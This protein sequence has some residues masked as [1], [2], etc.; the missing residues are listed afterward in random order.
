MKKLLRAGAL[1]LA[2][3][4]CASAAAQTDNFGNLADTVSGPCRDWAA[5]TPSDSASLAR[6]PKALW[7]GTAGSISMVGV[8]GTTAVTWTNVVGL[9]PVRPSKINATGTSAG[10]IVACF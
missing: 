10:G 6:V 3:L 4:S 7:I 1:A 5:I 8:G 2:L 9:L